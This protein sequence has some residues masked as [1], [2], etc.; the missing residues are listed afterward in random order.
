LRGS[1]LHRSTVRD[2][3]HD[4]DHSLPYTTD[5]S[6][7]SPG[8]SLPSLTRETLDAALATLPKESIWRVKGFVKFTHDNQVLI[9][10]WAF[11]RHELTPF[12][13]SEEDS[14]GQVQLTVMGARGDIRISAKRFAGMVGGKLL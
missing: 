11:G 7:A 6:A 9:L 5:N 4:H 10:N 8:C 3:G 2:N 14:K 12:N 1:V 13:D